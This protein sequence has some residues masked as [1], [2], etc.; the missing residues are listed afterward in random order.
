MIDRD[1]HLARAL[2][3]DGNALLRSVGAGQL[4]NAGVGQVVQA[5]RVS[6][7][8]LLI[9]REVFDIIVCNREFEGT[10]DSGQDL[11]DELRRE[12]QLPHSTIFLM[13]TTK[14][15][16]SQV[17]E[18]AEASLDG[19]LVRPYTEAALSQ[20][21]AEA[22]KRK[23]ELDD[24]LG[25]LDNG[26][27]DVAIAR[28]L[29]R[30]NE[31]QPYATY[32]GRLVAELLLTLQRPA[33]AKMLFQK[34]AQPASTTWARLGV[35]R[36]L[37]AA[38]EVSSA[39][40][41]V[42][43][44]LADDPSSADAH[45]LLGRLL[46]EQ[47]DFEGALV[48]YRE[49]AA[50]TPGCLLRNQHAGALAFYQGHG[51]AALQMLERAVA[52]GV[53]SKLFDALTLLLIATLRHDAA[54]AAGVAAIAEQLKRYGQRFPASRRLQRFGLASEVL[55]ALVSGKP[56]DAFEGLGRLSAQLGDDDFDLEAANTVLMLWDRLPS[57]LRP[58]TEHAALV[59]RIG[60]RFC[61]SNAIT[62]V[63][64]A[65]ARRAEPAST[66]VRA[67]RS[68]VA[69]L[70]ER[71]MDMALQGNAEAGVR[72]L[73]DEGEKTLNAKLLELAAVLA[74]RHKTTLAGAAS[75]AERAE[76]TLARSCRALNHIAGIQRSGRS[77][78]GLQLRVNSE[79]RAGV[80]A[81]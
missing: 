58:A 74:R 64:V 56:E 12:K 47:C 27:T 2:L 76:A 44:V 31:R 63:L 30:F 75:L 37:L 4:R 26:Q 36:C 34:M 6:D 42:Q 59:E 66:I 19:I 62:E 67:C 18:A 48:E 11:L 61:V 39:A 8:R 50:I 68:R 9:E 5:S 38:G 7:A 79:V 72:T 78:G 71:A 80:A 15:T 22:R 55:V 52:L 81:A 29:K 16:Y 3:V 40:K 23:R 46:V 1:I 57:E 53:T 73:L 54:D 49:A 43:A 60:L 51:E 28:A 20:R 35:A 33:D 32:C 65:S 41:T 45:D 77:P 69:E 13:V 25:A 17:M 24:I 14:A 10:N 21:L 70:A